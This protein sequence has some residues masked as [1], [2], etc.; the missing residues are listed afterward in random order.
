MEITRI[1]D[2]LTNLE[3]NYP[4]KEDILAKRINGQWV[5]YSTRE[6]IERSHATARGLLALG[7]SKGSRIISI[8]TN[9]PE[10]N[11]IDMGCALAGMVHTP[12]YPTL[13]EDDFLYIFNH[14]GASAIFVGTELLYK[15]I[16]PIVEQMDTPARL[17]VIDDSDNHFCFKQLLAEGEKD[18]EAH[19]ATINDV[20]RST[21]KDDWFTLIYT[22][23]TTGKPKGVMLSHYNL[24]FDAHG[25]ATR[26][27]YDHT[28]K[29]IS[30][31]PLCHAYERSMN[32]SYQELG[33][34]IYYSDMGTFSADLK[35][36]KA[37]GFCA[38]PRVLEMMYSK[39]ETAGNTMS[40]Y[41]RTIYKMAWNFANNFDNYNKRP[42]YTFRRSL[43]DKLVYNKWRE[44]LGGQQELLVVSGGSSIQAR[45]LRCFTAARIECYEGYGMTEA[46][47]VIAVNDPKFRIQKI[48]TVGTP[49]GGTELK[50]APDGEILTR[51]PH[52]MLGYYKDPEQTAEI[53]DKDGFL[54]TGDIGYMQEGKYLK[55][56]DRKKEI[57]KLSNGKYVAPQVIETRLKETSDF[58]SNCMVVGENEKF[59][60]AI[61][62]P[63][64]DK[65]I[66]YAKYK[67]IPFT[68]KA[69]LMQRPEIEKLLHT[70]IERVN[71]T[72]APHEQL[73]RERF[74]NGDWTI[75]NGMLSQ[76]LK[77]KRNRIF[78]KYKDVI[79][80]IYQ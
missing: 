32:Y 16:S 22:S 30:F 8:T 60:S 2:L 25:H 40:G 12:V 42:W 26:E 24:V 46:S 49:L 61:I 79:A 57:F 38:V 77:L 14:S 48:G 11:F 52:V 78:A 69:D 74:I 55:I 29:M 19:E 67:K 34:G 80:E 50:I 76:T 4:D 17:I 65:L 18:K 28:K 75:E 44:N 7:C 3:Q 1:F 15:K 31:L 13:S 6:Y 5:K 41:K 59:T 53:I 36:S 64:Y 54:H 33:M 23:G 9:R 66:T 45:I 72:L 39:L 62:I 71:A 47:P 51:G 63:A 70:E 43:Y 21:D 27:Y 10:W 37:D 73:K 56:T 58:I 68:D 35:D 20:M